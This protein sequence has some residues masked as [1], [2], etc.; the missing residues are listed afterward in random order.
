MLIIP[1][2]NFLIYLSKY[3]LWDDLEKLYGK[4]KLVILPEVAYELIKLSKKGKEK[5]YS[6]VAIELT[7]IKKINEKKGYADKAI[8]KKAKKL[9]KTKKR[10]TIGTMDKILMDKLNK[11]NVKILTIR[12]KKYI[13]EM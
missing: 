10:F 11:Q 8:L 9:K 3:K 5:E 4:Y 7:K 6:L 2:T 13:M 12:Q 1:D